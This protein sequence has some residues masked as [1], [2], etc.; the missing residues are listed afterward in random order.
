M[1]MRKT[2]IGILAAALVGSAFMATAALAISEQQEAA[3]CQNDALRF[4][5]PY[6]PDKAKIH[7]CLVTYKAYISP[8]CR[9]IIAPGKQRRH[10]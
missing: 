9:A 8:A 7:S 3:D 6:V 5:G 1:G 10:R 4:C 2:N